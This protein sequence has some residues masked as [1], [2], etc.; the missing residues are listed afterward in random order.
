MHAC[1]YVCM[2][3]CMYVCMQTCMHGCIDIWPFEP[4][5]MGVSKRANGPRPSC[6]S[7]SLPSF[8]AM[9][10]NSVAKGA[11]SRAAG[12]SWHY[13]LTVRKAALSLQPFRSWRLLLKSF[14]THFQKAMLGLQTRQGQGRAAF[15]PSAAMLR[16][17]GTRAVALLIIS[18]T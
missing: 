8:T 6:R 1:M 3:V 10:L 5:S 9:L 17:G 15:R 7:R 4:W 14:W 11:F 12:C 16:V 2:H 18:Y 13:C